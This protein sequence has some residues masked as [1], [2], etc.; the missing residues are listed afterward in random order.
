M[1]RESME[2]VVETLNFY[3]YAQNYACRY[4]P[5]QEKSPGMYRMHV[6]VASPL[7]E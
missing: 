5:Y 7:L 3:N 2:M 1:T 6:V 4:V